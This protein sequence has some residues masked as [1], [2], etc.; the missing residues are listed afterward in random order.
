MGNLLLS[1]LLS[2][3]N[4]VSGLD[5]MI[6]NE[7]KIVVVDDDESCACALAALRFRHRLRLGVGQASM[8][9]IVNAGASLSLERKD[10]KPCLGKRETK[11]SSNGACW[12]TSRKG[13]LTLAR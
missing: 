3:P 11:A 12:A 10:C 2:P 7:I 13:A 1:S 4:S 6:Q 5:P 8:E 9:L